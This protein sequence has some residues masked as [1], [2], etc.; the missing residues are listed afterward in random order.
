MR[1]LITALKR[2]MGL[3]SK[4]VQLKK[5]HILLK[6]WRIRFDLERITWTTLNQLRRP[7]TYVSTMSVVEI[8]SL[9]QAELKWLN[10]CSRSYMHTSVRIAESLSTKLKRF[11]SMSLIMNETC[12]LRRSIHLATWSILSD[13]ILVSFEYY[14]YFLSLVNSVHYVFTSTKNIFCLT[15]TRLLSFSSTTIIF[16]KTNHSCIMTSYLRRTNSLDS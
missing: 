13:V 2:N 4:A 6:P 10:T 9:A 5:S 7:G 3:H 14:L 16:S 11:W 15:T 8:C 1:C 12:Y